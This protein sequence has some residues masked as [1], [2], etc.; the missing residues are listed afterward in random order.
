MTLHPLIPGVGAQVR[1]SLLVLMQ[2]NIVDY[3]ER[4]VDEFGDVTND[5]R[6]VVPRSPT[7]SLL[8]HTHLGTCSWTWMR[9]WCG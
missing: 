8:S 1:N 9:C 2:Q 7:Q 5:E 6:Y 4:T 3:Q